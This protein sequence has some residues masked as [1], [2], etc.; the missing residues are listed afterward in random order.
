[1]TLRSL[2]VTGNSSDLLLHFLGV[3]QFSSHQVKSCITATIFKQDRSIL[4]LTYAM[5]LAQDLLM[6]FVCFAPV[7]REEGL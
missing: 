2:P 5:N 7:A 4:D 3:L 1:M 6:V